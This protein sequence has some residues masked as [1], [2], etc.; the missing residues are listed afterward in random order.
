LQEASSRWNYTPQELYGCVLSRNDCKHL[1]RDRRFLH[2]GC[3]RRNNWHIRSLR[4][5]ADC[6]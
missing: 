2:M 6:R 3:S 5:Q 4:S 1:R